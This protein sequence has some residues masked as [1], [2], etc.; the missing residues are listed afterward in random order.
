MNGALR[1]ELVHHFLE[2]LFGQRV[3]PVIATCMRQSKKAS[4]PDVSELVQSAPW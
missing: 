4:L 1:L 2:E 3:T